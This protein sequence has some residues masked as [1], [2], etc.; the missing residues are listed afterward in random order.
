MFELTVKV[1]GEDQ[2]LRK[3]FLV[4]DDD[5]SFSTEDDRL[6]D[7]VKQTLEGFKGH[8]EGISLS[9]NFQWD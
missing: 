3:K 9:S 1:K 5:I 6:Q 8:V 7:Y 2:T 4:Y